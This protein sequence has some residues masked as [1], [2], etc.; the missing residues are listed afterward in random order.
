M[1]YG[2]IY[3]TYDHFHNK[4]YVGRRKGHES[5]SLNYFGSGLIISRII[6][7]RKYHLEKRILGYCETKE[8]LIKA[9]TECIKFFNATNELYGYNL[10]QCGNDGGWE[11]VNSRPKS[12]KYLK[13]L[14]ERT[15]GIKNPMF[16]VSPLQRL[17][18]KYG[19]ELGFQKYLEMKE[20]SK[21]AKLKLY[22]NESERIKLSEAQKA[23][24]A[25]PEEKRKLIKRNQEI[26]NRKEVRENRRKRMMGNTIAARKLNENI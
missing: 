21:K 13:N 18:N 16:G 8:E 26:S 12:I 7:R 14:S 3:T 15:T 22:E 25:K 4:I 2:Y 9:E 1:S 23:R 20:K 5:E 17:K 11:T 10:K 19:D 24:F 6:K